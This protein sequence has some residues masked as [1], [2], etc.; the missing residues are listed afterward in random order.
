[1]E[2]IGFENSAGNLN[3]G[4]ANV[5]Q[6]VLR[7]LNSVLSG[8]DEIDLISLIGEE[9]D[10]RTGGNAQLRAEGMIV[11][12][13]VKAE[14]AIGVGEFAAKMNRLP[15]DRLSGVQFNIALLRHL[16][17]AGKVGNESLHPCEG[18]VVHSVA[19]AKLK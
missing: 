16:L 15:L 19:I 11:C 7:Q 8:E 18:H 13:S 9:Q 6:N 4:D 3:S 5:V 10:R 2:S 17:S 1:M 14:V 12:V